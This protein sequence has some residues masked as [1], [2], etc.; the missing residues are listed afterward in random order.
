MARSDTRNTSRYW[1]DPEVPGL[2]LLTAD[3]TTHEYAPH[4]HEA[5]VIAVTERG[6]AEFKSRGIVDQAQTST[7]LVFNPDEPH[8][9][10][11]GA[12]ERWRYRSFYLTEAAMDGIRDGLGLDHAPYFS[13]NAFRDEGLI[14]DFLALH[15][16]IEAGESLFAVRSQLYLAFGQLFERHASQRFRPE[17]VSY[18]RVLTSRITAY[19]REHYAE[20]I[21]LDAL[22]ARFGLTSFQMIRCFNRTLGLPPHACLTQ[23]RLNAACDRLKRGE[24]F[25]AAALAAGFYDQSAFNR[26]FKRVHGITPGQFVAAVA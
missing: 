9:G 2:S 24:S 15:R 1:Q 26:H 4:S 7:L 12:S 21:A 20:D 10:W 5:Y 18:E 19:F 13:S 25:A 16:A 6:G 3:F 23:I 11:L 14:S 22:A 8:S 17:R